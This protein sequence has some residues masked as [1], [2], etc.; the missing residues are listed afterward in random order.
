LI[1]TWIQQQIRISDENRIQIGIELNMVDFE[2]FIDAV[3]VGDL[4]N[5]AGYLK[6]SELDVNRKTED[7]YT[8]FQISI[9]CKGCG[10]TS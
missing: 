10:V 6:N 9:A 3:K 7:D 8:A 2:L 1:K 5:V 4:T